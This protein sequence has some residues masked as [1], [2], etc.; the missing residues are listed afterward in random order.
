MGIFVLV[1]KTNGA[2]QFSL[3]AEN[4]KVILVSPEFSCKAS[5]EEGIG[6]VREHANNNANFTLLASSKDSYYYILETASGQL[7]GSSNLHKSRI[8][9]EQDIFSVKRL[10]PGA[11]VDRYFV[12]QVY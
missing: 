3:R 1:Q 10:A 5:C 9:C 8:F 11:V 12:D 4:G 6:M 7:L 2:F